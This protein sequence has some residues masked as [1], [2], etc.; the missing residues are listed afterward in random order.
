MLR[1][2]RGSRHLPSVPSLEQPASPSAAPRSQPDRC[3]GF[4]D[5][6][7]TQ[8]LGAGISLW[9][10]R[11]RSKGM[12]GQQQAS[13]SKNSQS[14]VGPCRGVTTTSRDFLPPLKL[15]P[16]PWVSPLFADPTGHL[17]GVS[18]VPCVRAHG[19]SDLCQVVVL[20]GVLVAGRCWCWV[21]L[22]GCGKSARTADT[23]GI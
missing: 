20:H 16:A 15:V 11:S 4:T 13:S 1:C 23:E 21:H 2:C 8:P 22:A 12:A 18:F 5:L 6:Q 14:C 7:L 19:G 17:L 10:E 9:E 3:W